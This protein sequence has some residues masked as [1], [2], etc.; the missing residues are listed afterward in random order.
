MPE[1]QHEAYEASCCRT[2]LH[3]VLYFGHFRCA[4]VLLEAGA[5]LTVLDHKVLTQS[6]D[7]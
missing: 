5:S 6:P 2:A 3:R 7:S 4:A 1:A